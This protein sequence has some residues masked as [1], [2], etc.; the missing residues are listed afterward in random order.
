MQ[1]FGTEE[2]AK[3]LSTESHFR[4]ESRDSSLRS[5]TKTRFLVQAAAENPVVLVL[6]I[7]FNILSSAHPSFISPL[8]P[9]VRG[10]YNCLI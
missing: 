4:E 10:F 2:S 9:A 5:Y 1:I 6:P 3:S 7:C 8:D